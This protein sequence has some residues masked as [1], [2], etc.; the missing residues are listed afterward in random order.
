MRHEGTLC[1]RYKIIMWAP[2]RSELGGGWGV[3]GGFHYYTKNGLKEN[4]NS[5]MKTTEAGVKCST[6]SYLSNVEC[7]CTW[8]VKL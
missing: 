2:Q 8:K 5:P 3:K 6:Y 1:E 4:R 7:S